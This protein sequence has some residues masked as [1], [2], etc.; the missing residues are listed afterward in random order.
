MQG[1][2]HGEG[3]NQKLNFRGAWV[4]QMVAQLVGVRLLIAAQVVI[5]RVLRWSSMMGSTLSPES[6]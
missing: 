3:S 6:A 2:G 4:A 1:G 5:S